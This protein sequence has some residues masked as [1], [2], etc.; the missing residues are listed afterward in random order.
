MTSWGPATSVALAAPPIPAPGPWDRA[1]IPLRVAHVLVRR[2]RGA[3]RHLGPWLASLRPGVDP[4]TL[5][6]PWL[7]FGAIQW[8]Q[9]NLR[10]GWRVLELGAGGSTLFLRRRVRHLVSVEHDPAW[11]QRVVA[12]V[13]PGPGY[14]PLLVEGAAFPQ[15]ILRYPP[16]YFDL[17]LVDGGEDRVAAL[18]AAARRVAPGGYLMLDNSDHRDLAHALSPLDGLWRRDFEGIAPWNLHGGR[19]HLQR[20]T[21]WRAAAPLSTAPPTA[22]G[23]S[24][25]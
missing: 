15:V 12:R 18:S 13:P 22:P 25:P 4:L 21:L 23:G 17:V 5:G 1:L 2:D 7:A 20:T 10:T 9:D 6:L 11:H 8:L 3:W 19:L 24:A 16:G 14:E